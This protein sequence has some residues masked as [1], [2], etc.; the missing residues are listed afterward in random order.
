MAKD[1]FIHIKD[2]DGESTDTNHKNWIEMD[3]FTFGADQ[4]SSGGASTGGAM[5]SERVE[6]SPFKFTQRIDAA[7]PK[8][9]QACCQGKHIPEAKVELMRATGEGNSKLYMQYVMSDVLVTDVSILHNPENKSLPLVTVA[10][11]FGKIEWT[12]TKMDH[13]SGQS[14]G[15]V[16]ASYDCTTNTV[17]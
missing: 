15:N 14:S 7:Y 3:S 4:P 5:T 13:K 17:A 9:L 8:L 2:C 6:I 10:L 16:K 1:S 12:Y 11:T